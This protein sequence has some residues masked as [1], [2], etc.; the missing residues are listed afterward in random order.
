MILQLCNFLFH[1]DINIEK[2]ALPL[3][4]SFFT[5]QQLSFILDRYHQKAPSYG[6]LEYA[7]FITYFPQLIA[8]PIVLHDEFIPQLRESRGKKFDVNYFFDGVALFILGLGKKVLLADVLAIVVN[9]EYQSIA[10]LDA[11]AAWITII[12]Y[13]LELYFDMNSQTNLFV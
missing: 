7:C 12:C 4:I 8:G 6:F 13:M 10:Y 3:G 5:F 9:A 1:T 11:P 2:I